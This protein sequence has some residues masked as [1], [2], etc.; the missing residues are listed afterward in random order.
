[1]PGGAGSGAP[2]VEPHEP[3]PLK[4]TISCGENSAG[5]AGRRC[6]AERLGPLG[7]PMLAWANVGHGGRFRA[8]PLGIAA[9]LDAGAATLRLLDPPLS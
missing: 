4:T 6:S 8:F 2:V 3:R 1:L 7:V 5:W 9:E